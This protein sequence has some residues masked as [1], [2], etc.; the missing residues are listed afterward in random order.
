[1]RDDLACHCISIS[2]HAPCVVWVTESGHSGKAQMTYPLLV[3][4]RGSYEL[5]YVSSSSSGYRNLLPLS[6]RISAN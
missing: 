3:R 2:P 4:Q 5:D 6:I 1:M